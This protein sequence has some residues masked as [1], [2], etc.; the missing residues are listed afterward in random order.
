VA[1]DAPTTL[2]FARWGL[3]PHWARDAHVGYKM[4]NARSET[5]SEKP[6]YRSLVGKRRCLVLADGFYEWT[7]PK[8]ARTPMYICLKS[9]KAFALGG[10]WDTWQ[11]PEG[12]T[13]RSVTVVTTDA[14]A[15]VQPLHDRMPLILNDRETAAWLDVEEDVSALLKPY[16]AH[17]LEIYEVSRLV[18]SP[19]NDRPDC[20]RPASTTLFG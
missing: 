4:I 12:V 15:D 14:N 9:H 11:S 10:L 6:A 1:S 20:I 17:E 7:G 2:S 18:N 8:E 5:L 16:P 13:V 19:K 3:I